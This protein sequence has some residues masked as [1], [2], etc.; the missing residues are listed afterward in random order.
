MFRPSITQTLV[1]RAPSSFFTPSA[2]LPARPPPANSPFSFSRALSTS[3]PSRLSQ[4][5][6]RPFRSLVQFPYRGHRRPFSSA[7][8][9]WN[10]YQRFGNHQ[11]PVFVE[12]HNGGR[13]VIIVVCIAGAFYAFNLEDVEVRLDC[14]AWCVPEKSPR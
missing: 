10:R 3:I 12:S 13:G 11:R 2:F 14:F 5:L 8:P 4:S 6:N 9:R 7:G 1:R